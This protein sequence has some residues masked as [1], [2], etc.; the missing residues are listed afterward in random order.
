MPS[1]DLLEG[2]PQELDLGSDEDE[3]EEDDEDWGEAQDEDV[4][5]RQGLATTSLD[6]VDEEDEEVE[7]EPWAINVRRSI[8]RTR[9]PAKGILKSE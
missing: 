3:W 2:P 6:E 5:I 4:T 1:D 7:M 8:E 9:R